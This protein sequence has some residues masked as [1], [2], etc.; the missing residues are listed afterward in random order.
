MNQIRPSG[1]LTRLLAPAFLVSSCSIF[2]NQQNFS[3]PE[4][5]GITEILSKAPEQAVAPLVLRPT[6][7][8]APERLLIL[9]P[10]MNRSPSDYLS[11]ARAVQ[12]KSPHRL[13]IGI[14]GFTSDAVNP[15]QFDAGVE[16][17]FST[18]RG[19][20][21]A[22]VGHEQTTIA[23]HSVG[24]IIA[25]KYVQDKK[26]A[27]L[28]L[29]SSYLIRTDGRS[30]LPDMQLPVLTLTGDLDGQTRVTRIALDARSFFDLANT[31]DVQQTLAEKPVVVLPGIN[32]AQFAD[33]KQLSTDLDPQLNYNAAQANIAATVAD[34]I[35]MND[36]N[37]LLNS[38]KILA[39]ERMSTAVQK[40]K[41]LVEPYWA[42]REKDQTWCSEAQA[43]E[44][45]VLP[46]NFKL[47]IVAEKSDNL[48]SFAASKPKASLKPNGELEFSITYNLI[49]PH[50]FLDISDIPESARAL[51][52]KNKSREAIRAILDLD[53]E[54]ALGCAEL[55]KKIFNWALEK[56]SPE[57]RQRFQQRGRTMVFA[58]D[59]E[60]AS[61]IQWLPS[62][63][64][65][66]NI[67]NTNEAKVTSTALRSGLNVP[68]ML[69]GMHYCKLLPPSQAMEWILLEGLRK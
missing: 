3:T 1:V 69:A 14:L 31:A 6:K 8:D 50:N 59:R 67:A 16:Q 44:A 25:Q 46:A 34:F 68:A 33:G 42:A 57:V 63:L 47:K 35:V 54:P 28:V 23:G 9:L 37:A 38:D 58:D 27:G 13:W 20:G 30:S 26:F 62:K 22:S 24:G 12:E 21:F 60:F 48:S 49:Y 45:S 32:H 39:F 55:N 7:A 19:L 36:S 56:V 51:S 61:G 4:T 41:E 2:P 29:L 64:S 43:E 18:V 10:G 52:C 5:S 17:V 15:V 40:T 65:I 66:E 53:Q 11:L